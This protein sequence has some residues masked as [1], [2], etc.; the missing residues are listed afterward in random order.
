MFGNVSEI[1]RVGA[2]RD[3]LDFG[4]ATAAPMAKVDEERVGI[5]ARFGDY[6]ISR[7]RSLR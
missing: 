4:S 6:D 3:D 1:L 5:Y 7:I 2:A